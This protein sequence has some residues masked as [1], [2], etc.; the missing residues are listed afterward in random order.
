MR[1]G[2]EANGAERVVGAASIRAEQFAR[3]W[4][5]QQ[6]QADQQK[7]YSLREDRPPA[8]TGLRKN[9]RVQAYAT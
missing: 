6:S 1:A 4:P 3:N 5:A 8:E 2:E 7:R 9:L